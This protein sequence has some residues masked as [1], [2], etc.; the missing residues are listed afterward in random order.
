[1]GLLIPVLLKGDSQVAAVVADG[2]HHAGHTGRRTD[3]HRHHHRTE[4]GSGAMAML[5][6][7]PYDAMVLARSVGCYRNRRLIL[8]DV[9]L[10]IAAGGRW[11]LF[12]PNGVGKSTLLEMIA[13]RTY[14]NVG[15]L[16]VFGDRT[17]AGSDPERRRTRVAI[18]SSAFG[19]NIGSGMN[20][21][22]I[23]ASGIP[24]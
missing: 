6:E 16:R 13:M 9:N 14:P 21:L 23:V 20:P 22:T 17:V 3:R 24:R 10:T 7:T 8:A 11:V 5:G 15:G 2:A 1:M 4:Y 12:G 19:H 18:V